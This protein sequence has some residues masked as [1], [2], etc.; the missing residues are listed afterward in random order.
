MPIADFTAPFPPD[1]AEA[2]QRRVAALLAG[3]PPITEEQRQKAVAILARRLPP[4]A[5]AAGRRI[6]A[7]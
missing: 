2:M 4:A 5:P 7:A 1:V 3:L 6:D